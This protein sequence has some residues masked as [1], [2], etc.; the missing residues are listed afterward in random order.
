[1]FQRTWVRRWLL[2]IGACVAAAGIGFSH[3]APAQEKEENSASD[4]PGAEESPPAAADRI[5]RL[6]RKLDRVL[7]ELATLRREIRRPGPP[8]RD[9]QR[10]RP[11]PEFGFGGP[12][13]HFPAGPHPH[14][15]P[16]FRRHSQHGPRFDGPPPA[17]RPGRRP[18][19]EGDRPRPPRDGDKP[20]DGAER[21]PREARPEAQDRPAGKEQPKKRPER[22]ERAEGEDQPEPS[23]APAP[24]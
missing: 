16:E 9:G 6:E 24:A 7:E 12:P 11:R 14:F 20:R 19:L 15:R 1:M 23:R 17:G 2:G 4:R 13:P 10:G 3:P 18:K 21:P 8:P 5:E 22:K